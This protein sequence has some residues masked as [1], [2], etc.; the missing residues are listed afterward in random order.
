MR[1][2]V[3]AD[4]DGIM[5]LMLLEI[6]LLFVGIYERL[7][8]ISWVPH[9]CVCNVYACICIYVCVCMSACV[10][11]VCVTR[12]PILCASQRIAKFVSGYNVTSVCAEE[13]IDA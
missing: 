8:S 6:T 5:R 12:G 13:Y 9:A 4:S 10:R 2:G 11:V 1:N 7:G 3:S